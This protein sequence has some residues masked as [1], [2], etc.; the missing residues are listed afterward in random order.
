M[1]DD[2]GADL[3]GDLGDDFG[4]L[5]VAGPF[6]LHGG[7]LDFGLGKSPLFTNSLVIV[8]SIVFSKLG[9]GQNG[10]F[11]KLGALGRGA[12]AKATAVMVAKVVMAK[13]MKVEVM[14]AKVVMAKMATVWAVVEK[15]QED[16]SDSL[17]MAAAEEEE[18]LGHLDSR[19]AAATVVHLGSRAAAEGI[20]VTVVEEMA[21]EAEMVVGEMVV[22]EMVAEDMVAEDTVAAAKVEEEAMSETAAEV[23]VVVGAALE[24]VKVEMVVE[25]VEEM[26]AEEL[27]AGQEAD[28]LG[29]AFWVRLGGVGVAPT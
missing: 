12:F 5:V 25:D 9:G 14:M 6:F 20:S 22:G 3:Y 7:L 23:M 4:V 28:A 2:L 26:V 13:V 1:G 11:G 27:V 18:V 15:A 19:T 24:T 17:E 29:G 10:A 21:V 8:V 16:H